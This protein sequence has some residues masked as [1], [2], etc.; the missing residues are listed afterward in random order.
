MA[1]NSAK[2]KTSAKPASGKASAAAAK[3]PAKARLRWLSNTGAPLIDDYAKKL[4]TFL[5]AV[6]DGVVDDS[7]V[8]MQEERLVKLLKEVEPL[9]DDYV[10]AKV[11]R[12]LCELT[13]YDLM[14]VLNSMHR[15]RPKVKFKG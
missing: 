2:K 4:G 14:Q 12:L 8:R 11:T 15:A 6:A 13:A 10:H 1:K 3:K 7:E 9:L 5:D